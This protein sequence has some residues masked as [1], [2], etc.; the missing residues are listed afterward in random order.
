MKG[1]RNSASW[2]KQTI[3]NLEDGTKLTEEWNQCYGPFVKRLDDEQGSWHASS[4][5]PLPER[6]AYMNAWREG[7]NGYSGTHKL[8]RPNFEK[9]F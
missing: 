7:G 4:G 8:I 2:E 6:W 9:E 1:V 5:L 3:W